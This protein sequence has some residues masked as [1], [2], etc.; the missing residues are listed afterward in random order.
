MPRRD[1][2][3]PSGQ[4]SMT[5]WGNGCCANP[6]SAKQ[7]GQED[8][9]RGPNGRQMRRNWST[10]QGKTLE[11]KEDQKLPP[12]EEL[13]SIKE[14]AELLSAQLQEISRRMAELE[15]NVKKEPK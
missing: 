5:G 15:K 7:P 6:S 11:S 1:G 13:K 4:G 8:L 14:Q 3:G 2:T 12:Q 9:L 10:S